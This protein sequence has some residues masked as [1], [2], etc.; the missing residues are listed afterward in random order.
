MTETT[1]SISD[2]EKPVTF[3]SF[4]S[5]NLSSE[6]F[7]V[8]TNSKAAPLFSKVSNLKMSKENISQRLNFLNEEIYN[9]SM[10]I[11]ANNLKRV[12]LHHHLI[13]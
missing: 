1:A 8:F 5:K 9:L 13:L 7:N 4:L 12:A 11:N 2:S 6:R 3:G 10:L